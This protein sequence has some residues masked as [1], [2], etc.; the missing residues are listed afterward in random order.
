MIFDSY[1]RNLKSEKLAEEPV[2]GEER[3]VNWEVMIPLQVTNQKF[4][5]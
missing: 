2:V 4:M 5:C 3:L 1:L